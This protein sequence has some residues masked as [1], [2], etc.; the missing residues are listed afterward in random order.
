[1]PRGSIFGD[2]CFGRLEPGPGDLLAPSGRNG[3][4]TIS[5][6]AK[7]RLA[8][9]FTLLTIFQGFLCDRWTW[10]IGNSLII[11][12]ID[13]TNIYISSENLTVLS[14]CFALIRGWGWNRAKGRSGCSYSDRTE[15]GSV[16]LVGAR[17][18]SF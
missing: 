16:Q 3:R 8:P 13:V 12:R 17:T 7:A 10:K 5:P 9:L 2:T 11:L 15:L 6:G 18:C 14:E 1:M 4:P